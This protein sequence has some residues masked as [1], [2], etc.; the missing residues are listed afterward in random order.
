M[1]NT[2]YSPLTTFTATTTSDRTASVNLIADSIMQQLTYLITCALSTVDTRVVILITLSAC[3]MIFIL[4]AG[5]TTRPYFE[6]AGRTW[7]GARLWTGE[8]RCTGHQQ[9]DDR[10]GNHEYD[11]EGERDIILITKYDNRVIGTLV[12]RIIHTK[13][14]L[15][16][17]IRDAIQRER[18]S[19]TRGR[20]GKESTGNCD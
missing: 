8:G 17:H 19:S 15:C 3:I 13:Q 12:L 6:K 1:P 14:E 16:G 9:R 20:S 5:Y 11:I 10:R 4:A 2:H 18:L 7:T